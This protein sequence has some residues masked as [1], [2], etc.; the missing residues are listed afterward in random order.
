MLRVRQDVHREAVAK[1]LKQYVIT[2]VEMGHL[3][4]RQTTP[5]IFMAMASSSRKSSHVVSDTSSP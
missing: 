1:E 3:P 5:S 4:A 2:G